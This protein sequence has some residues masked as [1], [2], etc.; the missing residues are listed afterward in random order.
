M[1]NINNFEK[2]QRLINDIAKIKKKLSWLEYN[3][4]LKILSDFVEC[5]ARD[6]F[7]LRLK[8]AVG[9]DGVDTIG[10]KY[11]VKYTILRGTSKKGRK[12]F[13]NA[14]GNIKPDK[15]DFLVAVILDKNYSI[16]EV[17]RIPHSVV[18]QKGYLSEKNSFRIE[19]IYEELSRYR[20]PVI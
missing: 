3:K 13:S 18:C 2:A 15:F 12:K 8:N 10:N 16:V 11:Q 17:F 14:L 7:N 9:Y 1:E 19:K 6:R 4:S 5:Y 20:I